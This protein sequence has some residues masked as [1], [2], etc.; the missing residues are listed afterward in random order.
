FLEP[1]GGG[2]DSDQLKK[3]DIII[4]NKSSSE[5]PIFTISLFIGINIL[6]FRFTVKAKINEMDIN[7]QSK[8]N[9]LLNQIDEKVTQIQTEL[10][11]MKDK[12]ERK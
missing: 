6:A 4:K 12:I 2:Y 10:E 5:I 3:L 1:S 7:F 8:E 11:E 9:D